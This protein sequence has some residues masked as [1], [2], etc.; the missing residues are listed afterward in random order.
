[1]IMVNTTRNS[2]QKEI[3][4]TQV[5]KYLNH[6]FAK[7]ART[8]GSRNGR[9]TDLY[10]FQVEFCYLIHDITNGPKYI[11][12][13]AIAQANELITLVGVNAEAA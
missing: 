3:N 9:G 8:F 2:H 13:K 12:P 10:G 5:V 4:T 1:M 11:L 6:A 7:A